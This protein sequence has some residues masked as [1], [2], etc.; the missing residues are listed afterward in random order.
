M[1]VSLKV[2]GN[3]ASFVYIDGPRPWAASLGG[4]LW[5]G[6]HQDG[7]EAMQRAPLL[8]CGSPWG[9]QGYDWPYVAIPLLPVPPLP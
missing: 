8:P 9:S 4:R 7:G 1:V 3:Q 5:K 2:K 6:H